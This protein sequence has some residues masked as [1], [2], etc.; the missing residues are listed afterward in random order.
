MIGSLAAA[1]WR[2]PARAA[3]GWRDHLLTVLF[4]AWLMVGLFVDGWAHSNLA[5]LETFFTP[6]HALF[7]S[8]FGATAAWIVWCVRREGALP[9]GYAPAVVGVLSFGVGGVGHLVWHTLFGIERD[10]EAL[11]G[12][13]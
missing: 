10:A 5:E 4:G 9:R 11:L 6:W 13:T 8:G 2:D 12:P 1:A 3:L 7:Y